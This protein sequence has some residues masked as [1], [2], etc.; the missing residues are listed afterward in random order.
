MSCGILQLQ[1]YEE[2]I[3]LCEQSLI[4]AD[5]NLHA[6]DVPRGSDNV[7]GSKSE[8]KL[9]VRLWR[10]FLMAKSNFCLGRLE[11]ALDLLQKVEMTESI[12]DK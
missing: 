6:S 10:F 1:K 12:S 3:Q 11:E 5:K 7:D 4:I 8:G 9:R 2:V